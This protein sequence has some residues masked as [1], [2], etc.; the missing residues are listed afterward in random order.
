MSTRAVSCLAWSRWILVWAVSGLLGTA[1]A[2]LFEDDEARKAILDL[3]QRVDQSNAAIKGLGDENAQLRRAL[4]DLQ[5]QIEGLKAEMSQGRG[6]Q[7]QLARELS[8]VQMRQKDVAT[9]VDE[10]LRRFE[11]VKVTLDGQEFMAEPAEKRDYDAAMETFRKGDFAAAQSALGQFVQRYRRSGYTPSALFWL[12]NA[13]YAVKD[14]KESM[15]NFQQ[16][17]KTAPTHPRA[18]EAMLA[19]SNVQIELKDLKGARKTMDD[20]IKTYPASETAATARERLTR[21]R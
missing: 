21:L 13:Q 1:Q 8:E 18:P 15:A 5:G 6:A 12:G 16:M 3:R 17:L 9:G 11:P 20:L 2:G 14:Y 10:R 7:E 4:L 19:I